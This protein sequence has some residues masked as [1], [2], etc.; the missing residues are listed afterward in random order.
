MW[1]NTQHRMIDSTEQNKRNNYLFDKSLHNTRRSGW[2]I[3]NYIQLFTDIGR[4]H[5][6]SLH[7][8]QIN[9]S[10]STNGPA[11]HKGKNKQLK[12]VKA[13][14]FGLLACWNDNDNKNK[15]TNIT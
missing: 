7:Q 13:I 3:S 2:E 14:V 5:V 11:L 12:W 15:R 8:N 10:C 1:F 4:P 9:C 6:V